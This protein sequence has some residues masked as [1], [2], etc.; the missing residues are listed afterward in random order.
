MN[1]VSGQALDLCTA[2]YAACCEC[3]QK[4]RLWEM[5][6]CEKEVELADSFQRKKDH[7]PSWEE[8][9]EAIIVSIPIFN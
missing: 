8:E 7:H 9:G 1:Q 4:V 6:W 5:P 3:R 2:R